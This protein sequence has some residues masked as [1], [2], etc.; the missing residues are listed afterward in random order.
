MYGNRRGH[1]VAAGV[2]ELGGTAM[3]E[4]RPVMIGKLRSRVPRQTKYRL[5]EGATVYRG[6]GY[7]YTTNTPERA[8]RMADQLNARKQ[9]TQERTEGGQEK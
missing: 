8:Q 6:L 5:Y 7:V 3:I 9:Q 2:D 4:V 1:A